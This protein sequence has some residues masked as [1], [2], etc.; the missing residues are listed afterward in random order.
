M[1]WKEKKRYGIEP[2]DKESDLEATIHKVKI[3]LSGR[4]QC[5]NVNPMSKIRIPEKTKSP[6]IS[7]VGKGY[8]P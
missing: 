6:R 2:F 4:P 1:L 3:A 7:L 8:S 5:H